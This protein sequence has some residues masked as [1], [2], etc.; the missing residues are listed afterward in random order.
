MQTYSYLETYNSAGLALSLV[1][2][3][4]GTVFATDAMPAT[5][6][7]DPSSLYNQWSDPTGGLQIRGT[8]E[9]AIKLYAQDLDPGSLQFRITD[10]AGTL[11]GALLR[12]AY[13]S[14]HRTYL[15]SS[16]A[17]GSTA[18]I[19]V[20]ST[21]GF[22]SSG[23]IYIG[24]EAIFYS[25]T[26]ATKFTGV[27]RGFYAINTDDS[28][29]A[30]SPA[31]AIGND[32]TVSATTAPAVTDYPKTWFGRFCH[33]FL[34]VRDP[35]TG[36]YNFPSE[37]VKLWSGRIQSYG[38]D[39]D[40]GITIEAK[41]A[42]DLLYKPVGMQQWKASANAG[43]VFYTNE[44][45]FQVLST[46]G[47][48]TPVATLSGLA[49]T[50]PKTHEDIALA[51]NTQFN[52]WRSGGTTS[53]GDLWDLTLIDFG[54]GSPPRYRFTLQANTTSVVLTDRIEI[55]LNMAAW[56]MLGWPADTA[57]GST[58][59]S[60][61]TDRIVKRTVLRTSDS[62]WELTAPQAP[63]VYFDFTYTP[64]STITV[65]DE[66]GTF[67]TQTPAEIQGAPPNANGVVAIDG[68][69]F[70]GTFA[71]DY[72]AGSPS[73]VRFV[74][75][76]DPA[77]LVF[78]PLQYGDAA[79][80]ADSD[81][82]ANAVRLG[83][84]AQPPT[85]KQAWFQSGPAGTVLLNALLSTGSSAYNHATYD[86][87][88]W[89]GAAIPASLIDVSS[90]ECLDA[91][92]IAM[93]VTEPTPIYEYLEPVLNVLNRYLV[94]KAPITTV[95][96]R[97]TVV[98][99]T[100]DT[101]Q[102]IDWALTESTKTESPGRI[103][104]RR[105]VEGIINRVVVKYG[106]ILN[107]D[108]AT[109]KQIIIEDVASQSDYGRRRTV[110]I[111]APL[112][113]NVDSVAI[114][115]ITPALAYCGRPLAIAQV[116][117]NAGFIRM[118]PG[119]SV[120]VTDNYVLDPQTG[121]R[122]AVLY[123]WVLSTSFDLAT[124]KGVAEVIFLPEKVPRV[125]KWAPSAR[126]S[127]Y[128][129]GTKTITTVAH[130]FSTS[131]DVNDSANFVAGDKVHVY[132][133]DAASPLEWF[134]TI[135]AV[136]TNTLQ[137][138]TG[139]TVPAYDATKSYVVEYDDILT[140]GTTQATTRA[141]IADDADNSTGGAIS[142]PF[143]WGSDNRETIIGT[144]GAPRPSPSYTVGM[145]QPPTSGYAEKGQPASVHKIAYAVAGVNSLLAYKSRNVYLNEYLQN[146][147]TVTGT[148]TTTLYLAWIPI[149]GH[150]GLL[151]TR[152]LTCR[153][154]GKTSGGTSTFT[155]R[156][157]PTFPVGTSFSSNTYALG[158]NSVTF[159]TASTSFVWSSE[160]SLTPAVQPS[161]VGGALW[162][163]WIIVEGVGSAGGI[164]A[165]L[166]EVFVCETEIT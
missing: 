16:V 166:S 54:D 153:L 6:S 49:S 163:T 161:P 101:S 85:I 147:A 94:W 18:D 132:Q 24:D 134:D 133:L 60:G 65:S 29:L 91:A 135:A 152:G 127:S 138:T 109:A 9:Q 26:T 20:K 28:G 64:N 159:A 123:G 77:H 2:E 45:A 40:G 100:F 11:A 69:S 22:S 122:G 15:T 4:F 71:V 124:G 48:Y 93:L 83:D 128:N 5:Y 13:S 149:Y 61:S 72:E 31:H 140:V 38:D 136:G 73:T 139:L 21:A 131:I 98:R 106:N 70:S 27:F 160:L 113:T 110:T 90:W 78:V 114:A 55:F 162:G 43:R 158:S 105:G 92:T 89:G 95:N 59:V 107:A 36:Q 117:F 87:W 62:R 63:I 10:P 108:P 143:D 50:S 1:I 130:E 141:F 112:V 148:T 111:A 39:G 156:S 17:A 164:T 79:Q 3:G 145:F 80:G 25:G 157:S 35:L 58:V 75:Q 57:E 165:S 14:G 53:A 82:W 102:Q 103:R 7:S 30:F 37:A 121:S 33:L 76:L 56:T 86:V 115:S 46:R 12:E 23:F 119:D 52:T 151:V 129:A 97:M 142:T 99:P 74:A 126:L 154:R 66:I 47:N 84:A 34:H 44:D 88:A 120:S 68:G 32:V 41:S 8:L 155:L 137:L 150:A 125:F 104:V 118:A 96:P 116:S 67:F 146:A 81:P 19:N 42:I 51:I 144:L